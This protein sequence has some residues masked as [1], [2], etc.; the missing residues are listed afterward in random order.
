MTTPVER[1]SAII[2][3]GN[4]VAALRGYARRRNDTKKFAKVPVAVMESLLMH[5][6]NYPSVFDLEELSKSR[7]DILQVP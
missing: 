6:P 2:H 7:P 5:L 4:E 1:A 3:I